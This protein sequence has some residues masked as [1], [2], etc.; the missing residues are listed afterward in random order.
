[1]EIYRQ[2]G[3]KILTYR[4]I[5][6]FSILLFLI[7][8]TSFLKKEETPHVNLGFNEIAYRY[9]ILVKD[10]E[11]PFR[12]LRPG[13]MPYSDNAC[14]MVWIGK[15]FPPDLAVEFILKARNYYKE[16]KYIAYFDLDPRILP[17]KKNYELYLGAPTSE[18]LHLNLS[19]W[20]EEDFKSLMKVQSEKEFQEL[21]VSHYPAVIKKDKRKKFRDFLHRAKLP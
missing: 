1:M 14:G 15:N 21:I 12:I 6:G 19:A 20:K 16:L 2:M 9:S 8:C 17:D 18:A 3:K 11:L 10:E 4:K 7:S 13:K 5:F